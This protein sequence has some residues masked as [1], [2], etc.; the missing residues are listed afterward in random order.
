[1][2]VTAAVA[3]LAAPVLTV[4]NTYT[5]GHNG[6][7]ALDTPAGLHHVF[8]SGVLVAMVML[9]L[10][11]VAVGGEYRHGTITTTL[12]AEPDRRRMLLAKT[13]TLGALGGIVAASSFALA[14]AAAVPS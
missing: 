13:A 7:A 11:I 10:G 8:N 5:A 3:V 14:V 1:M 2:R 9:G 12:L 4:V 6:Q